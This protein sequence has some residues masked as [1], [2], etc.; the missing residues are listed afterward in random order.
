MTPGSQMR[1]TRP[2]AIKATAHGRGPT[3]DTLPSWGLGLCWVSRLTSVTV[4][5]GAQWCWRPRDIGP[6]F[7][8]CSWFVRGPWRSLRDL[9]PPCPARSRVWDKVT[10]CVATVRFGVQ[11]LLWKHLEAVVHLIENASPEEPP[12]WA[13]SP[14][15]AGRAHAGSDVQAWESTS[16]W[17]LEVK[18]RTCE[19]WARPLGLCGVFELSEK[20]GAKP[21]RTWTVLLQAIS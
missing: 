15:G 5:P 4:S 3:Q 21:R 8:G 17:K 13:R 11:V 12:S 1:K 2:R 6:A 18:F 14:H 20:T 16:S 9:S 19:Q 7:L 10:T